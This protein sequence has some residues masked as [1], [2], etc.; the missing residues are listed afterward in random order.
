M[1]SPEHAPPPHDQLWQHVCQQLRS[2]RFEH[3]AGQLARRLALRQVDQTRAVIAAP[4]SYARSDA[5]AHLAA[6]VREALATYFPSIREV[7]FVVDTALRPSATP[8]PAAP[9]DSTS[10]NPFNSFDSRYTLDNFVHCETNKFIHRLAA[11]FAESPSISCTLL[12]LHG[13][14][15]SGKTHLLR[16]I[17]RHHLQHHPRHRVLLFSADQFTREFVAALRADSAAAFQ[18]QVRAADMLLVDDVDILVGRNRTAEE[19]LH[20]LCDLTAR[21]RRVVV[22]ANRPPA[23]IAGLDARLRSQLNGSLAVAI[24]APDEVLRRACIHHWAGGADGDGRACSWSAEAVDFVV[25]GIRSNL[26]ELRGAFSRLDAESQLIQA[27][28]TRALAESRLQDLLRASRSRPTCR[29]LRAFVAAEYDVP[30]DE[31]ES[32]C[33]SRRCA[34]PRQIAMYLARRLTRDSLT[35]IG[36]AF[37][38]RDHSTVMHSIRKVRQERAHNPEF[39]H[40]IR[41]LLAILG[42]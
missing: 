8:D 11:E 2:D 20:A 9:P 5:Q 41:Q 26:R 4:S 33:R 28:V 21:G 25:H 10:S 39:D 13:P 17:G 23:D 15:G 27:P 42:T 12:C 7:E 30:E 35:S 34:R 3:A 24:P 18:E 6:P 22:T 16:A 32:P 14:V 1:P 29:S 36:L 38:G 19:F 40:E 31:L 37:G